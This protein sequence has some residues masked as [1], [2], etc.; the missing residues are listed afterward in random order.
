VGAGGCHKIGKAYTLS[1]GIRPVPAVWQILIRE[2]STWSWS[3]GLMKIYKVAALVLAGTALAV[4][5]VLVTFG[6]VMC[7]FRTEAELRSPDASFIAILEESDCGAMTGFD[8]DVMIARARP[9]L[10]ISWLGRQKENVFTL[11][12]GSSHVSMFWESPTTLVVDCRNCA[13]EDIHVWRRSWKRVSIKYRNADGA[14]G[15]TS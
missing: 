8:T 6:L 3:L 4:T 15:S 1:F 5:G 9:R 11:T 14:S 13:P 10:G 2:A 7:G 12:A